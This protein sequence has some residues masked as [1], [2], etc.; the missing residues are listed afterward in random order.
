MRIGALALEPVYDGYGQEPAHEVLS[1]PGVP[2]AWACHG[3]LLDDAG[4][5]ELTLGGFLL[6]TAGRVVLIDAGV[7]TINNDKYHGGQFLESLH[8]LGV[9]PGDVTDVVFTHLHFD[10]VGWATKKGQVVFPNATYRV[11]RADWA[12]FVE[13]PGAEPGAVRKLSPL[14]DRLETFEA[15]TTLAPGLDTR[16]V[17]GHT[18]GSTVFVVSSEGERALLLGDV[19]HS[20]VELTDPT[21]E[22]VFD[23]D[24]AAAKKV[25]AEL[26]DAA[27]D[28]S[29]VLAAAHFPSGR[30][31][32][33][34]GER[35]F[36]FI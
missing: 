31:V 6:R 15:D 25:R 19:A 17:P 4:N 35:R 7:G 9:A 34:E 11:H 16:H 13:G 33:V 29:D 2:D 26:A 5:L 22:A 18:P 27:T 28:R 10:H 14:T 21:W 1:R 3:H 23:V 32:T 20:T 24:P 8:A 12:H 36:R 30:L